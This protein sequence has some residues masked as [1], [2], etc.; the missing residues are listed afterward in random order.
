MELKLCYKEF[1]TFVCDHICL[2]C[3][4]VISKNHILLSKFY[5]KDIIIYQKS[6]FCYYFPTE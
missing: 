1:M 6:R 3:W 2:K 5:N 4:F